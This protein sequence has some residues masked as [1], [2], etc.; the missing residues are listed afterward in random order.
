MKLTSTWA[1]S[2]IGRDRAVALTVA[3]RVLQIISSIGTVLL[4]VRFLSPVE[5]GYYYTLLSLASLQTVFEMGFS[6]VILQ[7]A[8]HEMRFIHFGSGGE[9][10]GDPDSKARL[11]WIFRIALKWYSC[12]TLLLVVV[13]IPVGHLY[14]GSRHV[15]D[16]VN[17][18]GP[19]NAAAIGVG[20]MF[21]LAPFFSFFEGCQQV[22]SVAKLRLLQ[23]LAV[24]VASWSAIASHRGLYASAVVNCAWVCV[25]LIFLYKRIPLISSLLSQEAGS[26]SLSWRRDIWPFQW[27]LAV[28]W[29][30]SFLTAQLF[31]P[32]LFA[33]RGA[34][35]AGRMGLS[36]NIVAYLPTVA[37]CFITP[38]SAP[39]GRLASERRW[40]E[41]RGVFI[42]A[43]RT[44][45]K[46][47]LLM[48]LG[49]ICAVFLLPL[50]S[51]RFAQRVALWPT[52]ILL[53]SGATASFLIQAMAVY[54]R[55]FKREPLLPTAIAVSAVTLS[56]SFVFVSRWGSLAIAIVYFIA[57]ALV[58]LPWACHVFRRHS[59]G[60]VREVGQQS[61]LMT[62][63]V[64]SH[65]P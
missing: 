25:G 42:R 33:A 40:G 3:S 59:A 34:A 4:I 36:M 54:L 20:A 28:S 23:A 24:L 46:F 63:S 31:T 38:K 39:L 60:P 35:E 44:A 5:Q 26:P 9:L 50:V 2:L 51:R 32:I 6:V 12:A 15:H 49:C 58:G 64:A 55:S 22:K 10:L 13:L 11:A 17:W 45:F 56:L 43:F 52:F 53:L 62:A 37:L 14:F 61:G 29:T 48:D 30:C 16:Q 21:L 1:S 18:A 41:M 47:I 8:A 57:N 19:W 7:L 27:K 65:A